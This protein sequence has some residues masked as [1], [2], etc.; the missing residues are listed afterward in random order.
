MTGIELT[1]LSATEAAAAIAAGT[2]RAVDL[3][4]ACLTRI[5]ATEPTVQAWAFLDP[6]HALRQAE[7]L[8]TARAAG[9]PLGPLHGLPV[10]IKDVFD[11]A[12]MPTEYGTPL[13]RGRQPD[14]DAAVVARLRQAGAVIM[15]KT[16]CT[17]LAVYAPGKTR[18]PHDPERTPGGSS[19][20]SAAAV[21]ARMVPLAV[22]TQTNG[23]MIRPAS[24]CGVVG[25]KPTFGLISRRGVLAQSP[26]LDQVGVFARS[27][28]DAALLADALVGFDPSDLA[29]RP[30]P[31]PRMTTLAGDA[32]PVTP[33]LGFAPTPV[34]EQA[35]ET[36]RGAFAELVGALGD[37]VEEVRLA[38]PFDQVTG[39]HRTL[40]EA[41]LA[42]NYAHD[43][44]RG[45]KVLSETLRVMLERGNEV[46]AVDYN[47]ALE[48]I[49]RLNALLGE[50]FAWADA[51]I[52][53]ATMGTAPR[54]LDSTGSPVFCTLWTYLGVP[55]IS[56]PLFEDDE[57]MPFAVQ[58]VGARG[59]DARL[60]R[61]AN[62]LMQRVAS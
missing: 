55:A 59:D 49:P 45:R 40:M 60:L 25:F 53:P 36:T 12:D 61:T 1:E 51:L 54:G 46:R 22:G 35:D 27:V 32:P 44:E 7:A 23:S 9:R 21:A 2:L 17:E 62:W 52:T 43:F 41:D 58:M 42:K 29:T 15:G 16:V 19:S 11:T 33:R 37:D 34:W 14:S 8:D 28:A 38:A 26:P 39:W 56:L 48:W 5:E 50:A 47:R 24:Y 31:P 13:H 57:G 10:G 18:N 20:G 6:E 4:E 3:T 30:V